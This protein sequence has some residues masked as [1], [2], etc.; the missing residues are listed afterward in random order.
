[1]KPFPDNSFCLN[2]CRFGGTLDLVLFSSG[3]YLIFCLL[4]F[5]LH[6]ITFTKTN[7]A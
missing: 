4:E 6:F 7:L 5:N 1:M 3:L 2:A